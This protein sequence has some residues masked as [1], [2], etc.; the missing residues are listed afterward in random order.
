MALR[1]NLIVAVPVSAWMQSLPNLAT[2]V[3]TAAVFSEEIRVL[4]PTLSDVKKDASSD[5]KLLLLQSMRTQ[6][7]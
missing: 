4:L 5:A 6:G 7:D 3:L 1:N 2:I